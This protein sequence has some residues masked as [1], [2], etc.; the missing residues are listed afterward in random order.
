MLRILL[1]WLFLML[2]TVDGLV[3]DVFVVDDAVGI[4]VLFIAVMKYIKLY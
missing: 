2:L 3:A 1:L 4:A